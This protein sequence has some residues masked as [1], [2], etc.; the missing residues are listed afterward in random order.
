MLYSN[1]IAGGNQFGLLLLWKLE[2]LICT[3][4][5]AINSAV[6]TMFNFYL[7]SMADHTG[8]A[9]SSF[10]SCSVFVAFTTFISFML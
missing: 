8:P 3:I 9:L 1:V 10:S 4:I 7:E 5:E 6:F 2:S